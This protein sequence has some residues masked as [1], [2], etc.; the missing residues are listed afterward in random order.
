[1]GQGGFSYYASDSLFWLQPGE[2]RQVAIERIAAVDGKDR[3]LSVV[4]VSAWNAMP[5]DLAVPLRTGA[6]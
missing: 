4:K 1:L 5:Q 6:R 2:T 3:E